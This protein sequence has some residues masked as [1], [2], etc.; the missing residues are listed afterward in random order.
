MNQ[1]WLIYQQKN[2]TQYNQEKGKRNNQFI[3]I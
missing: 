1:Q 2:S 3:P